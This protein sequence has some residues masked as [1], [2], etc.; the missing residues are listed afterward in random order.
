MALLC[1]RRRPHLRDCGQAPQESIYDRSGMEQVCRRRENG[2]LGIGCGIVVAER[3]EVS[4]IGGNQRATAIGQH[5]AQMQ[6]IAA[7]DSSQDR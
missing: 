2:R 5:E 7:M 1:S 4:P 6:A 3:G